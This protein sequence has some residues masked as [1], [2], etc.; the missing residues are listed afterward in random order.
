MSLQA[1]LT[2]HNTP[3]GDG[4]PAGA[5]PLFTP[6]AP[7]ACPPCPP[8]KHCTFPE[9]PCHVTVHTVFSNLPPWSDYLPLPA[10]SG[11]GNHDNHAGPESVGGVSPPGATERASCTL[12][13]RSVT[14]F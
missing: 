4:R 7:S 3:A 14:A 10:V 13:A 6:E 9:G 5:V 12:S 8:T 1:S 11:S 2:F